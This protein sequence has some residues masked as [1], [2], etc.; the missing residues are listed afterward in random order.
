M[1]LVPLHPDWGCL[2]SEILGTAV[3]ESRSKSPWVPGVRVWGHLKDSIGT[4]KVRDLWTDHLKPEKVQWQ[5]GRILEEHRGP[6]TWLTVMNFMAKVKI[7]AMC[8]IFY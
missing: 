2:F 8:N 3:N 7:Q 4:L 6:R 5:G 1:L